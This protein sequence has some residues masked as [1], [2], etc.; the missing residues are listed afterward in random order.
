[1]NNDSVIR[2]PFFK[3]FLPKEVFIQSGVLNKELARIAQGQPKETQ[4]KRPARFISGIMQNSVEDDEF[5]KENSQGGL[6]IVYPFGATLN[7]Q[8]P[9]HAVFGTGPLSYP[10]E[11][12]ICSIFKSKGKLAVLGS[13]ELFSDEYFDK[14]ENSKLFVKII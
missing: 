10:K 12:P 1:M 14:E 13:T 11:R 2:T 3:Y 7:I 4:L 6:N 5:E 9:S 8:E